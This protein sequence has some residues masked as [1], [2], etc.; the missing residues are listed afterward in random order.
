MADRVIVMS[1]EEYDDVI[2]GLDGLPFDV[3]RTN[4]SNG[5][6]VRSVITVSKSE[7]EAALKTREFEQV[8]PEDGSDFNFGA[9]VEWRE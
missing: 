5:K 4:A 2:H 6:F 3:K 7:L 9:Q 1:E 8:R